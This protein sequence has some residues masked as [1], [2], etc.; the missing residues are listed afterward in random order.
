LTKLT[1]MWPLVVRRNEIEITVD[2]V[3]QN[4]TNCCQGAKLRSGFS[5]LIKK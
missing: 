4:G 5:K 3:D 2:Q 1:K